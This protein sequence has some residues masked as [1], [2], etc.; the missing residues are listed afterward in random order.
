MKRFSRIITTITAILLVI[1]IF[2]S[3][4]PCQLV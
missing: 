1:G 4:E 3:A 2:I